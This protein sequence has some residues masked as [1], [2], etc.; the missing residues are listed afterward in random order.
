[1]P[2]IEKGTEGKEFIPF[3]TGRRKCIGYR[4][5]ELEIQIVLYKFLLNFRVK[6]T[7]DCL[8]EIKY[9]ITL[10]PKAGLKLLLEKL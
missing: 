5:A 6:I 8:T 7:K 9:K 3:G 10:G 2:D 1:M 4:L